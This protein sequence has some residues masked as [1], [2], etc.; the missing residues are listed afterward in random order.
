MEV[1]KNNAY[2]RVCNVGVHNGDDVEYHCLCFYYSM[3]PR[4]ARG[5]MIISDCL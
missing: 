4:V 5:I 2:A 1:V 3:R